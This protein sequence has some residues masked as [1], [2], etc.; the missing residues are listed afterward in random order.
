LRDI[1]DT[2]RNFLKSTEI[3][4]NCFIDEKLAK[5]P[6][7]KVGDRERYGMFIEGMEFT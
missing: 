7:M 6:K 4:I 3:T 1:K 5:N 2:A